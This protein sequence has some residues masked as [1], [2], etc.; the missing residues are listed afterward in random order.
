MCTFLSKTSNSDAIWL[1]DIMIVSVCLCEDQ[2]EEE[3]LQAVGGESVGQWMW[4]AGLMV[5]SLH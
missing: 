3:G 2:T 4:T 1:L 5:A